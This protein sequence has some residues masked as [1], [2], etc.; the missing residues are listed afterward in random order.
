M[1]EPDLVWVV[2]GYPWA[3]DAITG[4]FYR[5]QARALARRGVAPT[6][7]VPTP[8]APWPLSRLSH[9]W[10]RYA[11]APRVAT[12]GDM[13]ILRPRYPN[14]AGEPA[15]ARPDRF[16]A[17][18]AWR[19][20]GRWSGA[21]LI[22]GHG[23][24]TGL[25]AW[26]VARRARLPLV[27]TFHGS[28]M[29]LWPDRHPDRVADLRAAAR[30]AGPAAVIAVSQALSRQ[31]ES[32]TGVRATWLPLGCDHR[33]LAAMAVPRL[34]A[35]RRLALP[36]ERVVV[37]FVGNLLAAKGVLDLAE[38]LRTAGD[39]FLG[40]FVGDG[41]AMAALRTMAGERLRLLGPRSHDEVVRAMSA[42]DVLVL[43]SHAEG[44]PTVIVEAASVGLPVIASRAGGIPEL[45]GDG[46]GTLLDGTRP[47][48]IRAAFDWFAGHREEARQ[49][50]ERLH[51][52]V[53]SDYDVDTNAARLAA[54]Y[55]AATQPRGRL[56]A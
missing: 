17:G 54:L 15:W 26:R 27:L 32:I 50:A 4:I 35:R 37:L 45:L 53:L 12:D 34:E 24:V 36:D 7:L 19:T 51:A 1:S 56:G 40:L 21:R 55:A 31:V 23:S 33:S 6:V 43:P 13:T 8:L 16:I 48:D 49:A 52:R 18:A 25:A 47:E 29:N 2:P 10:R 28:D 20:A 11:D 38:A 41:P 22:H 5:T 30:Y 39:Q 9:R 14:V 3:G 44:L 46:C 42:A